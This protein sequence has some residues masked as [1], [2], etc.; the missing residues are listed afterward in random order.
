M[1]AKGC[2][3]AVR[4]PYRHRKV[5]AGGFCWTNKGRKSEAHSEEG[6]ATPEEMTLVDCFD[7]KTEIITGRLDI[8][9]S[10]LVFQMSRQRTAGRHSVPFGLGQ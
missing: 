7:A 10:V 1:A 8:F 9:C 6:W 5:G 4:T 2:G 3:R